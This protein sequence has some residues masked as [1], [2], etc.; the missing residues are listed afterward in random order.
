MSH[1]CNYLLFT[2]Y[3]YYNK[4]NAN[5][6][7][8]LTD[9]SSGLSKGFADISTAMSKGFTDIQTILDDMGSG[10]SIKLRT[11]DNKIGA[12]DN[13]IGALDNT[14][15]SLRNYMGHIDSNVK[16]FSASL[17][18][19]EGSL[20]ETLRNYM[21]NIAYNVK[22]FSTSLSEAEGSLTEIKTEITGIKRDITIM[23]NMMRA[24]NDVFRYSSV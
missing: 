20:T 21:E 24:G 13:K 7:M 17:S 8:D 2:D 11:L 14:I 19:A 15:R 23:M 9:I 6:K 4:I 3:P 16:R 12:L 1:C 10:R 18:K 5:N 22:R